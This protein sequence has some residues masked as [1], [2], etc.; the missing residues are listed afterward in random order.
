M[1]L[2]DEAVKVPFWGFCMD[3]IFGFGLYKTLFL[4]IFGFGFVDYGLEFYLWIVDLV[5]YLW[6]SV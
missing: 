4:W 2:V 5:L 3:L 1:A 6:V